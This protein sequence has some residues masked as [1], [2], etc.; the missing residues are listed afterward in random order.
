MTFK[1]NSA[2]QLPSLL[3]LKSAT[4]A[5]FKQTERE[6]NLANRMLTSTGLKLASQLPTST[7]VNNDF[8]NPHDEQCY[9]K[10]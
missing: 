8:S 10:K 1:A 7:D 3:E 4:T 5:D 2:T 9:K 6:L